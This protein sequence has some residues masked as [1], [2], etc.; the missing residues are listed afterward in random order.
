MSYGVEDSLIIPKSDSVWVD[1]VLLVREHDYSIDYM[2]A[3]ITF[4]QH[5]D[6]DVWIRIKYKKFPFSLRRTYSHRQPIVDDRDKADNGTTNASP[7]TS[8][9]PKPVNTP[10]FASRLRNSGSITRGITVGS[11]QGLQ[12]DSGLRM[13]ISGK[14]TEDVEVIASLTDRNTPI[15]PE[16][17]T[18][19]LQEIDKVFVQLKAP[20]T[21]VTLGDYNLNFDGAEFTRYSRKLEGAM[22]KAHFGEMGVTVSGAVSRGR[23]TTNEFLGQEG[24]Q[25]P[26][27]L[28][29]P[30]G[31]INIIVLAGT[32]RVWVD[33]ELMTRGEN[34]DYVIEYGNG[35]VTFSRNRLITADSRI[36][37]DFQF[38][39]ESFQRNLWGAQAKSNFLNEKVSLTTTFIRE[40]DDKD[41]PLSMELSDDFIR[42]LEEAGDSLAVVPGDSF[43]GEGNGE[44]I[45]DQNDRFAYVGPESGDY[46]VRF[47]FVGENNGDYRNIGLGRFEYVGD[48]Q[49]NYQ[50]FIILPQAQSHDVMGVNLNVSPAKSLKIDGEMAFTQFD[51]N[52]YSPRDD[53][54]NQGTAYS[55]NLNF[56]PKKLS[57]SGMSLGDFEF[58]G[59]LRRKS[60]SF[61][62][63]DRTTQVEFNRKWNI[64]NAQSPEESIG[65]FRG[66]YS[67]LSGLSFEGGLGMLSKSDVFKSNRWEFRSI[68]DKKSLPKIEYFIESIDRDNR[69]LKDES[70]WLRQRGRFTLDLKTVKPIF[71]YEGEI[72]EDSRE[73]SV[74]AGFRFD[75]FTGG[76][77]VNPWKSMS[78][79]FRYNY[80]DDKDRSEDVFVPKSVAKTQ[81]FNWS[82]RNWHAISATATYTHR[83]REF[84]DATVQDTRTDLADFRL[85]YS[86]RKIG[87][88][89][90]VYY[91]ISNT[92]VA[93]QEEVFREV[94]EGEGNFRFNEELG[95]FEPDP[96][97]DFIRQVIA[98]RDFVPVVELRMRTDLRITPERFFNGSGNKMKEKGF[99]EKILSPLSSETFLRID[100][101]TTEQDVAK[102][103]LLN[104]RRFQQDS[105]TIFGSI[106]LRQDVHLWENSR[107]FSLRYRYR[108]RTEKNNQLINGGQD[109]RLREHQLR[110]LKRFSKFI[111]TQIEFTHSEEDRLFRAAGREDR[112][113][114]S[115]ELEVDFAYRPERRLE[116]GLKSTAS[117]NRDI[118]TNPVTEA[119]LISFT[120]RSNYSLSQQGRFRGEISWT[121]VS[122]SP[123][124][125]LI[126]FEL[127]NGNRAG[128]T[129]RWNFGFDYRLTNNVQASL[130]YFG[131]N[132]PDRPDTQHFAKVEMRA[133]F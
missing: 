108:N 103:Y 19:T 115:N 98:T 2:S 32:E 95:E 53:D 31:Q 18:Q 130:S 82:L 124:N 122:V 106:E 69:V 61:R 84:A 127:T 131:R 27:Q 35:Q 111:T 65:E 12:V 102:I 123:E 77:E 13:Q 57:I 112:K 50:P 67:P 114:R 119:N 16:G 104:L 25:G 72:R 105:T 92:Q 39:D 45:K 107:E 15:Q 96:F 9:Q 58:R 83:A 36:T 128:T 80:R 110:T 113:V 86:P 42:S 8:T 40:S 132:A 100:E 75:S 17:N 54:D 37:V 55:I 81:S 70:S 125:Q 99:V 85:G 66:S 23:F 101:R 1:S 46:K 29:G 30:E 116:F 118:V 52:L 38:S 11:N 120:P 6:T 59:K 133:F 74:S 14:L 22:A 64:S 49:G 78:A 71:D 90:N 89:G 20:N 88:R 3:K 97:G 41:D 126:P 5:L 10:T 7:K 91:Q 79:S 60:A 93:R 26:Y 94:E 33:G 76:L 87:V 109:R 51:R 117:L 44:Y 43:V 34:N 21:R 48:K 62:D 4:K 47:S 68:L 28:R 56:D 129:L 121:R 24:K 73:D 63:I